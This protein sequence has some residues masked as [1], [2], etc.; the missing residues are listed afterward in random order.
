MRSRN[1]AS[2]LAGFVLIGLAAGLASLPSAVAGQGVTTAGVSGLVLDPDGRPIAGA[3]VEFRHVETGATHTTVSDEAGRFSLGNLRPGGPWTLEVTRIGLSPVQRED[4]TLSA[5]QR[6]RLEVQLSET[7]VPLPEL[8]VRVETDPE[9]DPTRM[10]T[11]TVVNREIIEALPTISRDITGFARLSPLV[12]VD[13]M[14]TSV[15]GSNIR[16]NNIQIDGALSQD[17]FGLSPTGVAGGQAR[18]RVIPLAAI[19]ELQ[20]LAAPYDVRQSG[21]TGG[22]L[23]A[24]TRTGSNDFHG[25]A[26][27]FFR[28]D[29]L[30]GDAVIGGRPRAP[31][32]LENLFAGFDAGGAIVRDR[33]HFFIAGELER[34]EHPPDGFTVGVDEIVRTKLDPD[35]VA[36][37]S[38]LLSGYGVDAGE[39][40]LYTLENNLA[41]VFARIDARPDA[42]NSLMLRYNLAY[43]ADD[44]AANRLAGDA[45]EMSSTGTRIESR[46]HSIGA[47]WLSTLSPGWSNDLM[48]NL[49]FLRDRETANALYPR[50]EVDLQGGVPGAGFR[51]E[52]RAGSNYSGPD[53]ELDQSILQ[54]SNALTLSLGDHHLTVGAGFDRFSIR[55]GYLPGSLGSYFFRSADDLE[56]NTPSEYVIHVPLSE[57]AGTARF[58]VNQL[59]AFVQEETR[60]G[61]RLNVRLGLR[62]DIPLMPDA[63]AHNPAV[64]RSFGLRTSELPSGVIHFS[65]RAGFNLGL[66]A[67]RGT[68]IRGG[69]GLFTG[70]PPFAWLANAYQ[71]TGLSSV[72]VT[73]RRRNIGVPD[74]EIVPGFDP[75][76]PPPTACADGS[77]GTFGIPGVTAFD[78]GFRF[79]RDFKTSLA[80]DHRLPEGFVLSLEGI[81][82][83]AVNQI[84][85][86][87]INIGLPFLESQR[88]EANGFTYGFGY[89]RREV[90]ANPGA[91]SEYIDPPPGSPPV[92]REPI[93]I[94]RRRD[95]GFG[96]VIKIGDRARNFS[97]ALSARLR[98]RFGDRLSVDVGYAFNRSADVRSLASLDAIHN[99]GFTA[100]ER[101]P[102]NPTRQAS[103]FDRPH[104]LVASAMA[105][106]PAV[107]GGGRLSLLYVGQSGRPYSYVYA[108]DINGDTYPGFGRA[109]DLANDLIFVT[110]S[111]FDFPGG[112][113][114]PVSGLLFEQL[115]AQEPCLE[116]SRLRVMHRNSC[117]TPWSNELDFRFSQP[118]R[119]GGAEV[120]LTLDV[121]NV[122]NLINREWGHVQTVNPVVQLLSV[123]DRVA[124]DSLG[125]I[126]PVDPNPL[127]ARYAGPLETGDTGGV[128]A[129]LPY[130]PQIGASQWQAQF[131]V[132][133]RFR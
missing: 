37:V 109:L 91:G 47:Q 113:R 130:V 5:G 30:V 62:M 112:G 15:A 102:N 68:Q 17:V 14:G 51:R 23:N 93:F 65:P 38:N 115:V 24:V 122:L 31:G 106:L 55:R 129:A 58:S 98:K 18:G 53:G 83:R 54:I 19:E 77:P 107:L 80:I 108:D 26:F 95:E 71:N 52:L 84:S 36:R 39:A 2:R 131:G 59:S 78:P 128:R 110:E 63:P 111:A 29:A 87:D 92:R 121:L 25:S 126:L 45:Y 10:G 1:A 103:L 81:Y 116:E 20:V 11:A 13:E 21:F 66:G 41:N 114:T 69:A 61:D 12:A 57:D 75:A 46:N 67:D 27:G 28:N 117:R 120:T 76:A 118:L 73:C 85:F 97:Y 89:S 8:A 56:A 34:R 88:T 64:E 42:D 50:I 22:V 133:I 74:P 132:A 119:L 40:G 9:F 48:V 7:A 33:L 16:F 96:Q 82:A 32:E 60:L 100:V 79:P 49:Q 99:F 3:R 127:R 125:G 72:F 94:P 70:R 90:F 4:L 123:K 105:A 101:D 43:A 35:S 44:P 86:E 124:G 6:L 104:R